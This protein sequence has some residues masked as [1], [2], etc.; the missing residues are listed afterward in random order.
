MDAR[1]LPA[2][3]RAAN[4][5]DRVFD[6]YLGQPLALLLFSALYVAVQFALN[7]WAEDADATAG[8]HSLTTLVVW[9]LYGIAAFAATR[10]VQGHDAGDRHGL[11]RVVGDTLVALPRILGVYLLFV[12]GCVLWGLLFVL[13]GLVFAIGAAFAV[14][15]LAATGTGGPSAIRRSRVITRGRWWRTFATLLLLFLPAMLLTQFFQYLPRDAGLYWLQAGLAALLLPILFVGQAVMYFDLEE[16]ATAAEAERAR[17]VL[18]ATPAPAVPTPAP[19]YAT[20][21]H[22]SFD[23]GDFS[24]FEH[25]GWQQAAGAYHRGFGKLTIQA[26][27]ALLDAAGVQSG[28]ELL[29]VASGPGYVAGLGAERGARVT[30]VDFSPEMLAIARAG[31][32]DVE[33]RIADAEALPFPDR[34][35]DAVTMAFLLGHL[36]HPDRAIA[37]AR[38][39]LKPHRRFALAWWQPIDR[40]VAFEIVMEA[41]RAHGRTEV[42]LPQGPPFDQ[43]SDPEALAHAL[44]RAGFADVRLSPQPMTWRVESG[45]EVWGTYLHG[46]VRTA[47]LLREQSPEQLLAIRS[48]VLRRVEEQRGPSGIELS[49]PCWVA[50]GVRPA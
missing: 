21:S 25:R 41:V 20:P 16:R 47:G 48:E 9:A 18:A 13:P 44:E 2:R 3:P 17:R 50:S 7:Q 35:F 23:A 19:V 37:E 39:V 1:A 6:V 10:I 15:V 34:R 4:L 46:S 8:R 45:E 27:D 26:A 30:G 22:A 31:H 12:L 29:D 36:S 42:D 49:M 40:A 28:S 11:A 14:N 24:A 33:F 43:F 5:L 38:R 32:P